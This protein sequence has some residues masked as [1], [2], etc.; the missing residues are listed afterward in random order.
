M[1]ESIHALSFKIISS[2]RDAPAWKKFHPKPIPLPATKSHFQL[3]KLFLRHQLPQLLADSSCSPIPIS[4]LQQT[5]KAI[6]LLKLCSSSSFANYD[7][8]R[9]FCTLGLENL[10]LLTFC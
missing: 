2:A 1:V 8:E 9:D 4:S 7:P 3:T 5:M 6:S 10:V